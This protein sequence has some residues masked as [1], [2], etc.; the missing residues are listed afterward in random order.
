V[1]GL[2]IKPLK[3]AAVTYLFGDLL[4]DLS[5]LRIAMRN[6]GTRNAMTCEEIYAA[7]PRWACEVLEWPVPLGAAGGFA[8]R[9]VL[10]IL[11]A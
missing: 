10:K 7:T 3:L 1:Q 2:A 8:P 5:A 4:F 6:G 11:A 9:S